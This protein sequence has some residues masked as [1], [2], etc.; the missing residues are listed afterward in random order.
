MLEVRP[1]DWLVRGANA[2]VRFGSLA[3]IDEGYQDVRFVPG[4][5]HAASLL[6]ESA[7][8]QKGLVGFYFLM[9]G[10]ETSADETRR[11]DSR[12]GHGLGGLTRSNVELP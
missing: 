4:S 10:H 6:E 1:D 11:G 2:N 7:K 5:G 12:V 3:D 9:S 8:C